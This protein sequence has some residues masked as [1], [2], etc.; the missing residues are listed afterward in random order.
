MHGMNE[1]IVSPPTLSESPIGEVR[2]DAVDVPN[3]RSDF[4]YLGG[5]V[6]SGYAGA[7]PGRVALL[8][9]PRSSCPRGA[10]PNSRSRFA[11]LSWLP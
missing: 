2:L 10:A 5:A 3:W 7:V 4:Y 6:G 9:V 1:D 11:V 8:R